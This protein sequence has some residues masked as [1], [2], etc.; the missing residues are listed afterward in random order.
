MTGA[1]LEVSF[2]IRLCIAIEV[3]ENSDE[4][5]PLGKVLQRRSPRFCPASPLH[6]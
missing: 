4:R 3:L 1:G 6:A 5:V 2:R